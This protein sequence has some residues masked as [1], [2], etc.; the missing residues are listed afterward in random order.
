MPKYQV[1]ILVNL[2]LLLLFYM[3]GVVAGASFNVFDWSQTIRGVIAMCGATFI[4]LINGI[5][6]TEYNPK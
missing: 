3:C 2:A 4:I 6:S 1:L 5:V